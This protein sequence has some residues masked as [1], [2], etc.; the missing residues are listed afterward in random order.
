MAT[1][2]ISITVVLI[3]VGLMSIG[4]MM[5]REPI[6]G[7]CGGIN[8]LEQGSCTLCGGDPLKCDEI[9]LGDDF[10]GSVNGNTNR[11][12]SYDASKN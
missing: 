7:S 1:I 12:Q 5:G 6:K 4:V 3:L 9:D 8:A 2:L 11:N 10:K